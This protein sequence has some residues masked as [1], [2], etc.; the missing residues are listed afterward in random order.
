MTRAAFLQLQLV[1]LITLGFFMQSSI[2]SHYRFFFT[3]LPIKGI[4]SHYELT[5][6]IQILLSTQQH[7]SCEKEVGTNSYLI[8]QC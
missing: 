1:L 5:L 2:E 7:N 8:E 6:Y 4:N 3:A